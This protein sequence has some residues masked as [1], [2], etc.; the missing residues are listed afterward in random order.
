[1]ISPVPTSARG[2]VGGKMSG[3]ILGAY[4]QML[5]ALFMGTIGIIVLVLM[6]IV[7]FYLRSA[8]GDASA[9]TPSIFLL[10]AI[11]GALGAFMSALSRL[12]N[13]RDLPVA[14]IS[15]ELSGLSTLHMAIYSLVPAFV[16]AI[17]AALLYFL[18]AG[19]L[20]QGS[21]F[22][23]FACAETACTSFASLVN[24]W[25]PATA[26]DFAKVLVW[27]FVAG[28]AERLVPD[29]LGTLA[30]SVKDSQSG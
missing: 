20:L 3:R 30:R 1:M 10:V 18:F 7:P 21:L 19:G 29:A 23:T 4:K 25:G 16:G 14:L 9:V 24:D 8:A 26:S 17:S 11:G 6:M 15:D 5:L 2:A 28:F 22:P 27:G 12:Y 13:L